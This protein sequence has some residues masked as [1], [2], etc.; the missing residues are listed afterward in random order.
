MIRREEQDAIEV[1]EGWNLEAE[2]IDVRA[3]LENP[4]DAAGVK[5]TVLDIG[6][7]SRLGAGIAVQGETIPLEFMRQLVELDI[8]LWLSI[9][10][11]S[12]GTG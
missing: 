6:F 8:T 1:S 7:D 9:F 2:I 3:S 11:R 10:P 12:D 5:G 4:A